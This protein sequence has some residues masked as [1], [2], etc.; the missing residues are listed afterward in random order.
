MNDTFEESYQD[1]MCLVQNYWKDHT[2]IY[3]MWHCQR[4]LWNLLEFELG[5]DYPYGGREYLN[6]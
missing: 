6:N 2:L 5:Q 1:Q 3:L 4:R